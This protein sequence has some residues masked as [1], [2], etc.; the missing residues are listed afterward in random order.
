MARRFG[1]L[2]TI[3][4]YYQR[5]PLIFIM[6]VLTI[7]YFISVVLIVIYEN[8]SPIE[9]ALR[10]IP[11]FLG[12]LSTV[13]LTVTGVAS[14]LGLIVYL[15]FLSVIIGMVSTKIFSLLLRGGVVTK[16]I[17]YKNHI[18]ICG[19]NYQAKRIIKTLLSDDIRFNKP[20]VVLADLEKHPCPNYDVDFVSGQPWDKEDLIRAG[21]PN[22]DTAIVLTDIRSDRTGNPDG[23]ALMIT[24]AIESLNSDVHTCVQLLSSE[25]RCHLENANADEIICLD[26][27]GG[28]LA[29]SSAINHGLSNVIN[30]LLTFDQGSEFY[31]FKKKIPKEYVGKSFSDIG[32]KLLDKKMVL[33]AVETQKDDYLVEECANDWVHSSFRGRAI[34]INPQG[35]YKLRENDSL[36]IISEKE[37]SEL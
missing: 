18:V 14:L 24:L 8:V 35:E 34:V 33:I 30:E 17:R 21:V 36:F 37:P 28:N 1:I 6:I 7:I 13:E 12:D 4:R 9:A 16:K 23:E 31:R 10:I 5:H 15:G 3:V 2:N 29:V 20:I 19:W 11:S 25:N 27:V 26:Q 22:A 32:K